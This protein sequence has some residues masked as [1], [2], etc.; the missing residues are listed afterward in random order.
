MN[1]IIIKLK[2]MNYRKRQINSPAS[3]SPPPLKNANFFIS[4]SIVNPL[5][6]PKFE[7]P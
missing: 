7:S 5:K 4:D 1:L 6:M 2:L 3:L